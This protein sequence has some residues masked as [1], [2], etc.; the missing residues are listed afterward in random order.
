MQ[1]I[2]LLE[3]QMDGPE[4]SDLKSRVESILDRISSS[5]EPRKITVEMA[6]ITDGHGGIRLT[7]NASNLLITAMPGRGF[8]QMQMTMPMPVGVGERIFKPGSL[9]KID[10]IPL[11]HMWLAYLDAKPNDTSRLSACMSSILRAENPSIGDGAYVSVL[12]RAPYSAETSITSKARIPFIRTVNGKPVFAKEIEKIILDLHPS[13]IIQRAGAGRNFQM[14]PSEGI[15]A[16]V[17]PMSMPDIL[18]T[19]SEMGV[20]NIRKPVLKAGLDLR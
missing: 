9:R 19:V 7:G 12:T 2:P 15:T 14:R 1:P 10:V 20:R 3:T 18:R 4:I 11:L 6:L 17:V 13:V 16:H 5:P 8:G